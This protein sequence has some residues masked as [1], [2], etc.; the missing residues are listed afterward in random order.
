MKVYKWLDDPDIVEAM[1]GVEVVTVPGGIYKISGFRLGHVL[2][3]A[4]RIAAAQERKRLRK[5][6]M[7][8]KKFERV[9]STDG[10][11]TETDRVL[12]LSDIMNAI[13]EEGANV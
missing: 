10:Y 11:Y 9:V 12:H 13:N 1:S 2:K 7:G 6:I 3:T 4:A 5:A 8:I